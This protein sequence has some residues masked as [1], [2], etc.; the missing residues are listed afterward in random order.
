[1]DVARSY[2]GAQ[3]FPHWILVEDQSNARGR[4]GRK[5]VSPAGAFATT[6]VLN[7]KCAPE[8]AALYS[9]V[10]ACALHRTL[11]TYVDPARLSQKWPNDVLLNGGKIAGILLESSSNGRV[12]DRLSVGIGVNLGPPP[13]GVTDAAFAP[14][15]LADFIAHPPTAQE[16]LETLASCFEATDQMFQTQGFEA[17]RAEWMATAARLGQ[18]ITA[19]TPRDQQTGTFEGIDATG[20]LILLTPKGKAVIPA[21]DIFF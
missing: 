10:T 1:M 7:P 3:G 9:F 18:V 21:A 20:N 15:G 17:I 6:A 19:R 16:F 8:D 2:D 14:V 5:W 11:A 13:Q 12:V 4:Q